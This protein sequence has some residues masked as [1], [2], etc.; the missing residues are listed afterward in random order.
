MKKAQTLNITWEELQA[1]LARIKLSIEA[2]D[3][4]IIEALV[5][6]YLK[7]AQALSSA[8]VSIARLKRFFVGFQTDRISGR[9]LRWP[10]ETNQLQ[11]PIR[12]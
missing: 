5:G 9:Q 7:V 10:A 2:S 4:A 8:R 6:T 3:Y 12:L 11:E 1:C